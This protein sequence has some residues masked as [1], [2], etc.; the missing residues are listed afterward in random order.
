LPGHELYIGGGRGIGISDRFKYH[1]LDVIAGD[2]AFSYSV[3][4]AGTSVYER[5]LAVEKKSDKTVIGAFAGLTG[6]AYQVPFFST[7]YQTRYPGVGVYF[8]ERLGRW[9]ISS[10]E[11]FSRKRTAIQSARYDGQK[12]QFYAYG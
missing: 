6:L 9:Q 2:S 12:I 1:G 7:L 3:D 8:K 10:L 4:G 11:V 5:G